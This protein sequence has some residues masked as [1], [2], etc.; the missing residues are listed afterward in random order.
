MK[1]KSAAWKLFVNDNE[2]GFRLF[3]PCG[4]FLPA[5]SDFPGFFNEFLEV[6]R[7]YCKKF[8]L[9]NKRDFREHLFLQGY[10]IA[11]I[12]PGREEERYIPGTPVNGMEIA[13]GIRGSSMIQDDLKRKTKKNKDINDICSS[14]NHGELCASKKTRQRPVWFCEEFDEYV[15]VKEQDVQEAGSLPA[16]S[17]IGSGTGEDDSSQFK[18]LC[19][20]CENRFTCGNS[21]TEGGIWHC[22]EYC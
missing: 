5:G 17:R 18:G 19:I 11:S 22:E 2:G 12:R 14:C 1:H 8:F 20:N 3:D 4:E 21:K 10:L 6:T 7:E 13:P 15:P 16:Q 9:E